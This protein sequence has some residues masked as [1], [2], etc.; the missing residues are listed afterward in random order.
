MYS[1]EWWCI[2]RYGGILYG[3]A[4]YCVVGLCNAGY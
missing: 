1:V 3:R 4:V 2:M